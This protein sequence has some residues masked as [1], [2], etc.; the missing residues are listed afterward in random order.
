MGKGTGLGLSM[1][2]GIVRQ[3][4]GHIIVDSAPGKGSTFRIY[5]PLAEQTAKT[6]A[7][8]PS[9]AL[10]ARGK[11]NILIVEDEK[12]LRAL[13]AETLTDLGYTV[14]Q[15]E[16]GEAALK[17]AESAL[18]SFDLLITDMVM[19]RM[20]GREL[21]QSLRARRPGLSVLFISGYSDV[22]PSDEEFFN[23]TTQFLQKPFSRET[24]GH[25]VR[26]L[27]LAGAVNRPLHI[28]A[29]AP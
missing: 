6:N 10:P 4:G 12:N 21:T 26:E 16:N 24:L 8:P 23:T 17:L 20:S 15:A 1:V 18:P 14:V 2:Y 29:T 22:I 3:S 13:L 9:E 11:G 7:G 5:L 19:P 27:L 25:R 28:S